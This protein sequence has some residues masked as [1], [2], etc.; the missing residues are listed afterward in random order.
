MTT[1]RLEPRLVIFVLLSLLVT[2]T[3]TSVAE[4]A[5]DTP[6][7]GRKV[8]HR[9]VPVYPDLAKQMQITGTVRLVAVVAPN[10][11]VKLTQPVGGNPVLLKS[12]EDA[13]LKWKFVTATE[14]SKELIELHFSPE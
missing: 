9:V 2:V 8:I 5:S 6:A 14:E 10:G 1:Q 7:H 3:V 11:S 12:A 13:V 4:D